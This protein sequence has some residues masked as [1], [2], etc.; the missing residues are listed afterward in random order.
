MVIEF[1]KSALKDHPT[2]RDI[3]FSL[4]QYHRD[5]RHHDRVNVLAAR[6][7][8]PGPTTREPAVEGRILTEPDVQFVQRA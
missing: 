2:N 8:K 5:L 4:I 6:F 7:L 1:L 3:L